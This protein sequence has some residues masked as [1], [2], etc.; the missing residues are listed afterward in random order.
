M[1]AFSEAVDKTFG[2]VAVFGGIGVV[3][4]VLIV[5]ILL[6]V[7]GEHQQNEQYRAERQR[8]FGS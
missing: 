3:A 2:L 4:N 6:Q 8:R 1:L 5:Y 7:R